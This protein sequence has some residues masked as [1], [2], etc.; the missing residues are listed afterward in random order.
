MTARWLA[1]GAVA[2]AITVATSFALKDEASSP[3]DPNATVANLDFTLKDMH[4]ADVKLAGFRGKP[5]VLNFWATWCGP[6]RAEIPAL[7]QLV[8]AYR[9]SNLIVLGVSVDDAPEDLLKFAYSF[10]MNY[11]VLVGKGHEK[12]QDLYD[13]LYFVPVTWFIRADGTVQLKHKGP[14]S[15]EFL[16]AQ[17]KALVASSGQGT[18]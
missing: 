14:A 5:L 11:P 10:G 16:E 6:C 18:W 3:G 17:V 2:A 12:F 8:D 7:A 15:R 9:S 13:A 4:G 1:A